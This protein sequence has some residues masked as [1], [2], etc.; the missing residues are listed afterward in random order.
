MQSSFLPENRVKSKAGRGPLSEAAAKLEQRTGIE[1]VSSDWHPDIFPLD[2]RCENRGEPRAGHPDREIRAPRWFL[3]E[4]V[5]GIEPASSAWGA[6]VLPLDDTCTR[7]QRTGIEPVSSGW[8]PDIF[9]LDQRCMETWQSI[10]ALQQN[11]PVAALQQNRYREG[12]PRR[13]VTGEPGPAEEHLPGASSRNRTGVIG[14]RNRR[15]DHWTILA[16]GE[17][18]AG[19]EPAPPRW[20][21]ENPTIGRPL[22]G[23]STLERTTSRDLPSGSPSRKQPDSN[24]RYRLKRP[25]S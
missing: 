16:R 14:S 2:Q 24:R 4:Q 1:P 5:A 23:R 22:H 25:T 18:R 12:V 15:L 8:H 3:S 17:Q 10:A 19:I 6:N 11:R 9:P 7:E 21:P 20:Q 13:G